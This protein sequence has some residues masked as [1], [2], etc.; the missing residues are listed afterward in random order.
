MSNQAVVLFS[1]LLFP[2]G[3]PAQKPMKLIIFD[4]GHFHAT[5]LQKDM[6]PWLDPRVTVYAP[7]GPDLLEYLNRVSLFNLRRDNPTHWEL[8]VRT[9]ADPM[10]AMLREH[11]GNIVVFT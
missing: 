8:D 3:L 5:L 9:S 7:L 1:L 2:L 4:P 6:Y 11:P 10:A